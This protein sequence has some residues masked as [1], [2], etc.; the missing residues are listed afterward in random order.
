MA[1]PAPDIAFT[2]VDKGMAKATSTL[3][4]RKA[5]PFPDF[6]P[7]PAN[8]PFTTVSLRGHLGGSVG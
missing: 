2:S 1:A 4:I 7:S 8:F 3:L 6:P 5:K